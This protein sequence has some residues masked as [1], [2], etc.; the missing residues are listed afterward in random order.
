[1]AF[2]KFVG[3][4]RAT[5]ESP[6]HN[7]EN[8]TI[9]FESELV[10]E[11]KVRKATIVLDHKLILFWLKVRVNKKRES[12]MEELKVESKRKR[13]SYLEFFDDSTEDDPMD[14]DWPKIASS[15]RKNNKKRR[16]GLPRK[17]F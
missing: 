9:L 11:K 2:E 4:L 7:S 15:R 3:Q 5:L 1:M 10:L 16:S 14:P 8:E 6:R 12:D 13:I 17:L